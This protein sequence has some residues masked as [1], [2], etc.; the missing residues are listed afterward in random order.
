[1]FGAQL[2]PVLSGPRPSGSSDPQ[3]DRSVLLQVGD[4][5]TAGEEGGLVA[6]PGAPFPHVP[7]GEHDI[8]DRVPEAAR[9]HAHACHGKQP[10]EQDGRHQSDDS[11][12]RHQH[13]PQPPD[14]RHRDA[15]GLARVRRHPV[16]QHQKAAKHLQSRI[17]SDEIHVRLRARE[18]AATTGEGAPATSS[19]RSSRTLAS[20]WS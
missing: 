2:D 17:A 13:A 8:D 1:M 16:T 7:G 20:C 3:V 9:V 11:P 15:P 14:V 4:L 6:V 19:G 5:P 18:A 12:D 10:R